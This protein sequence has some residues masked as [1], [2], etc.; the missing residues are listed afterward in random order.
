[1]DPFEYFIVLQ[2]LILGLGIAQLLTGAADAISNLRNVKLG[3]AHTLMV[4]IVFSMHFQEWWYSYE[5]THEIEEWTSPL[6]MFLLVYPILLYLLA[7][8]LFP[9]GLRSH[10]ND[11]EE[12]YFDQWKPLFLVMFAIVVMSYLQNVFISGW[13]PSSQIPQY[14]MIIVLF[15][16]L[17]LDVKRK[18]AHN[19]LMTLIFLAWLAAGILDP[20]VIK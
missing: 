10:E 2:S 17:G 20:T 15:A 8:M 3:F 7:R 4:L 5:Y 13:A 6:V 16:F 18:L 11:L 14:A 19:I 9:T 12:Y 1:M